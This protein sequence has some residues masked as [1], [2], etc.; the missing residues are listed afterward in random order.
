MGDRVRNITKIVILLFLFPFLLQFAYPEENKSFKSR[1]S[2][3]FA[4]GGG[5]VALND[6][7]KCL[8]SVN[9]NKTFEYYREHFPDYI[10]GEIKKL[11][12]S[13]YD[14]DAELKINLTSRIGVGIAASGL[15]HP[16]PLKRSNESSLTYT[17]QVLQIHTY[18]YK[19]KVEAWMPP[20]KLAIYYNL[21]YRSKMNI[22]F[23][24]GIGNYKG[25]MQE[26]YKIE[27]TPPGYDSE[28]SSRFWKSEQKS[29]IGFHGGAGIE[30]LL[31][32]S[33][34]LV[35]E[36]QLRHAVLR[37]FKGFAEDDNKYLGPHDARYGFLY[38]HTKEDLF[39]GARYADIEVW[40]IPPDYSPE[41][42]AN[43]RKAKLDLSGFSLRMGIRIGLF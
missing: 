20:A 13:L 41:F 33:L 27:V 18:T 14:W 35:A 22:F 24:L 21:P 26:Y 8:G 2:I 3:K 15:F 7:N 30:Y 4:M 9:E 12:T 42:I 36:L 39:L 10:V 31:S 29:S 37:D 32:K 17:S 38:Y 5:S 6:I 1:F 25:K 19:P 28:W 11:D 40:E 34:A 16:G 43:I 23:T